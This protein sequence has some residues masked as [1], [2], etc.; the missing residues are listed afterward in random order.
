MADYTLHCF[1]ESGN[2]YKPALMLQLAGADWDA[3]FVDFMNGANRS[4]EFRALNEMGEVPVLI[5]HT[6]GDIVISQSGVMLWHLADRF[7]QFAARNAEEHREVLRWLLWDN[8][9][10]TG[11]LATFRFMHKFMGKGETPEAQFAKA[12]MIQAFK[13]LNRRLE[14]REWVAADRVTIADLS[15]AGYC[16]WPDHYETDWN[17]YPNIKAW[18]GRIEALPNFA[19]PE[20]ILPTSAA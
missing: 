15:L 1:L 19:R 9:K 18:L 4:P 17:D 6:Q 20:D 12:R 10:F 3:A 2:A 16:F 5:D 13:L 14:E 11:N 7:D 8:H